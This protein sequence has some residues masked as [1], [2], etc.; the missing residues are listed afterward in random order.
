MKMAISLALL[1]LCG[2][3]HRKE[4]SSLTLAPSAGVFPI[5]LHEHCPKGFNK[6]YLHD[7]YI[8]E[9]VSAVCMS[10]E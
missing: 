2:C 5:K 10:A 9:R 1:F 3:G 8:N 4:V 7:E 6:F